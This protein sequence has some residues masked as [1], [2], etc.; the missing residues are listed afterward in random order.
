MA[1]AVG[2]RSLRMTPSFRLTSLPSRRVD[3]YP[4]PLAHTVRA[5]VPPRGCTTPTSCY[6]QQSCSRIRARN[7]HAQEET[8]AACYSIHK[9]ITTALFQCLSYNMSNLE[10][11]SALGSMGGPI[12]VRTVSDLSRR[13]RGHT[14]LWRNEN[15][16][17]GR[18]RGTQREQRSKPQSSR[19]LDVEL[20]PASLSPS[21]IVRSL[22]A[23]ACRGRRDPFQSFGF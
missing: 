19:S 12:Q 5:A 6:P 11:I 2:T 10:C 16:P 14:R 13:S 9:T 17:C 1:V 20:L 8:C 23:S 3:G 7:C 4:P 22:L 15:A 21:P 18:S